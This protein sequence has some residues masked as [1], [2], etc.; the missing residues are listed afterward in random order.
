MAKPTP[1]SLKQRIGHLLQA[2]IAQ[3]AGTAAPG[4]QNRYDGAGHGRR[5]KGWHAPSSGPNRATL[6]TDPLRNRAHDAMRNGWAAGSAAST[7]KS[8]L[9]GTGIQPRPINVTA[10]QKKRFTDLWK[11]SV[12]ELDADGICD[13]YGLQALAFLSEW[14]AGE[15]YIRQRPRR[16]ADGLAVPL[17]IQLLE[18]EMCPLAWNTLA[19]ESGNRIIQGVEFDNLGRRVAYWM[20]PEHPGD[21]LVNP[22]VNAGLLRR[23]PADQIIHLFEPTR[24]GQIRGVSRLAPILVKL[25]G[26]ENFDDATSLRQ[27][28]ANLFTV[29]FRRSPAD[30]QDPSLDPVTG[31]PIQRDWDDTPM[32]GLEPGTAQIVD[33]TD[34]IVFANPPGPGAEY[35][36]YMRVQGLH[37]AAGTDIPYALLTGDLSNIQ[38][39]ALRVVIQEFR[40]HVEQRR[41][42][43]IHQFCRVVRNWWADSAALSGAI[44]PTE[45]AA[46]RSVDWIPQA[47]EY[48]HPVQDI[49][50]TLKAI[51]GGLTSRDAEIT[52]GWG[53]D[54]EAVDADRLE[55]QDREEKLGLPATNQPKVATPT[56]PMVTD[57]AADPVQNRLPEPEPTP[58]PAQQQPVSLAVHLPGQQPAA[59]NVRRA[60]DGSLQVTH[61][62]SA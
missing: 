49:E 41:A 59:F 26:I 50:A 15:C 32:A 8:N 28:L 35:E 14:E 55:S 20:Y 33:N 51:E 42:H 4:P 43:F 22:I 40:R 44:R 24:P 1:P 52:T 31:Q 61:A 29:F 38:D 39:R 47:W 13:F 27:E 7:W 30:V 58:H 36:Q 53:K 16:L 45:V 12:P 6:G 60:A 34:D 46:A 19:P 25:R 23:I 5:M 56:A 57:P 21:A 18:A 37:L 17:Q 62:E 3:V 2:A 11:L 54:P 10:S 48:I 9:V